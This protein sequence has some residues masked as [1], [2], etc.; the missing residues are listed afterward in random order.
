MARV[1]WLVGPVRGSGGRFYGEPTE[2]PR[3]GTI[4]RAMLLCP[5]CQSDRVIPL[6]FPS[7]LVEQVFIESPDRPVGKCVD[8]GHRL[9]AVE[10]GAQEEAWPG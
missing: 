8:C 6:P 3:A 5:E 10:V 1:R 9:T 2:Y 4:A 7:V